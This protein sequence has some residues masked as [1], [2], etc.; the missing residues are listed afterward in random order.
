[1]LGLLN[2]AAQ[3]QYLIIVA[4]DQEEQEYVL[5]EDAGEAVVGD[6]LE[7]QDE[8]GEREREAG[9]EDYDEHLSQKLNSGVNENWIIIS[10]I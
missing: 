8:A 4:C 2:L 7:H 10:L 3:P 6:D 5:V 9:E 1:M